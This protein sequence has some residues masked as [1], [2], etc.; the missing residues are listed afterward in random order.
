MSFIA[1]LRKEIIEQWRTYRLLICVVVLGLF[2][3]T[4]PLMA[5]FLPELLKSIPGA[6]VA[7]AIIPTP[8]I[9]DAF[10]QYLK[11]TN[12]FGILLALL[13]TMGAVASEKERGTAAIMLVKPLARISFLVAKFLSI[14][15]TLL[16]SLVIA[17][18]GAYYYTLF[19]FGPT[20]LVAWAA[21]SGLLLVQFMVIIAITLLCS[22]LVR[23]QAAAAGLAV[24]VL[25]FSSIISAVPVI[26][27]LLP[28]QLL[29]WSGSIL[30]GSPQP[31]WNALWVSLGIILACLTAAWI[32]FDKQEL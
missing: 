25:L 32:I 6:E 26:A 30:L 11:N 5:K 28:G 19:L 16:I 7:A 27:K 9:A 22:T 20:D 3:M 4:S 23:S 29:A 21:V 8:T 1:A 10:T 2:G 14:N 18:L 24:G 12:Q 17:G 31:A 15:L 13:I